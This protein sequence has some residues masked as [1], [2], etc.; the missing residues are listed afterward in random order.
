M[1][2]EPE[3]QWLRGVFEISAEI[4]RISHEGI[5]ERTDVKPTPHIQEVNPCGRSEGQIAILRGEVVWRNEARQKNRDVN[6][7]QQDG[8]AP[9]FVTMRHHIT[10]FE[11]AGRWR[12]VAD[13]PA[14]SRPQE[15]HM[16]A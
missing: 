14:N 11:S 10:P 9:K 15:T 1:Y 5:N 3:R 7:R 13:P 2:K 12:K 4:H 6:Q 8:R 16:K